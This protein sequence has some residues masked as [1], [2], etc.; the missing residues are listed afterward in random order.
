MPNH[1]SSVTMLPKPLAEDRTMTP[2]IK[3]HSILDKFIDGFGNWLRYRREIREIRNLDSAEFANIAHE[4][5]ITPADLDT[6]VRQGSRAVDELPKLLMALGIDEEALSRTQPFLLRDMIRVCASCQ[7]KHQCDRDLEAGTTAQHYEKYCLN[8]PTI[9]ALDQNRPHTGRDATSAVRT[10]QRL[11]ADV[12]AG[13]EAHDT[14]RSDAIRRLVIEYLAVKQI[15]QLLD[16]SLPI[17]ERE[18]RIRGLTDGP[19]EFADD[20]I[21]LPLRE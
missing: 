7:Q 21:D 16:P 18:R 20:R 12:D 6:F 4:L 14:V 8:A 10:S 13:A 11:T 19:P 15:G 1:R 3:P 2:Q 5:C 17:A 9:D